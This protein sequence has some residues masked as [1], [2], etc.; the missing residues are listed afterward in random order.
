LSTAKILLPPGI[1]T[2]SVLDV[3]IEYDIIDK[4]G[5]VTGQYSIDYING[6]IY[7]S[8]YIDPNVRIQYLSTNMYAR[9]EALKWIPTTAYSIK[10]QQIRINDYSDNI[11][12][13]YVVV[14]QSS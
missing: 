14:Q 10:D 2:D 13:S 6:I 11:A 9:Y 7:A 4:S 5:S 1:K 12:G 3:D 8:S